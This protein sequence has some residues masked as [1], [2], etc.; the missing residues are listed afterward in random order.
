MGSRVRRP[1]RQLTG[2]AIALGALAVLSVPAPAQ[3]L[4][5]KAR[6]NLKKVESD[7]ATAREAQR[8]LTAET[9]RE[10]ERA[11]ALRRRLVEAA[12]QL[13]IEATALDDIERKLAAMTTRETDAA[14]TLAKR[15]AQLSRTLSVLGRLARRPPATLAA[16]TGSSI[17]TYRRLRLIGIAVPELNAEAHRLSA[18]LTELAALRR[19]ISQ[20]RSRRVETTVR[21]DARRDALSKLLEEKG[22]LHR[23]LGSQQRQEAER[24][25]A[26]ASEARDLR[27]LV[28]KLEA[29]EVQHRVQ[30][31][32]RAEAERQRADTRRQ[33]DRAKQAATQKAAETIAGRTGKETKTANLDTGRGAGLA[34][35]APQRFSLRR[36]RLPMPVT[37][38]VVR[39][40]GNTDKLGQPSRGIRI[41]AAAQAQVVSPHDG[42][43][44]FSGPFRDYG[45]MLILSMGEGYHVLL[46]GMSRLYGVVGQA[47][48]A[49]EPIGEMGAIDAAR[50]T[51]YLEMRHQG[52]PINPV[53]WLVSGKRKVSG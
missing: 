35:P 2:L 42:T 31:T 1:S 30:A 13:R 27:G 4:D 16:D 34:P 24:A 7:L 14:A 8:R 18:E 46:S 37:G 52:E 44:V 20:Q 6:Q 50:P 3:K 45:L 25:R 36:G 21:L 33:A 47:V 53:P 10:K 48:L 22:A 15:R 43:I 26:L 9:I 17:D 29:L 23:K 49:G 12:E 28:S 40:F 19:D 5:D 41:E 51:L 39:R 32:R 38:R 11:E